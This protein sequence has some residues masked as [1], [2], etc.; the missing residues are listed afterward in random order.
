M[1]IETKLNVGDEAYM[2][3]D[4][5][6]IYENPCIVKSI[7]VSIGVIGVS[8]MYKLDDPTIK[9]QAKIL[10]TRVNESKVFGSKEDAAKHWLLNQGLTV[11]G[12]IVE[13]RP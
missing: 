4:N 9:M 6:N 8:I 7:D 11:N 5:G 3:L 12:R 13:N 1:K 10:C 2:V